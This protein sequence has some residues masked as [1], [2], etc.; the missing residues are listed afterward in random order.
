M[1]AAPAM[2]GRRACAVY[3][4]SIDG[5]NVRKLAQVDGYNDH[6]APRWSRDGNFVAFDAMPAGGGRR[7]CFPSLPTEAYC[8]IGGRRAGLVAGR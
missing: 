3:T 5:Q 7:K 8:E 4:M 6:A 2:R 1:L